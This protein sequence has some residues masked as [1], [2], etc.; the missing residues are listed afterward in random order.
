LFTDRE[1]VDIAGIRTADKEKPE[2]VWEESTGVVEAGDEDDD[3]DDDAL[4]VLDVD[5]DVD[6]DDVGI[7]EFSMDD[8]DGCIG[9]RGNDGCGIDVLSE[10]KGSE[11][12]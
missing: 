3:D 10:S 5:V 7:D 2:V 6:D 1:N 4:L 12:G 9:G 11:G 8:D